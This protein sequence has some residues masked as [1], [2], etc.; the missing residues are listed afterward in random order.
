[1]PGEE[2]ASRIQ[3]RFSPTSKAASRGPNPAAAPIGQRQISVSAVRVGNAVVA[4]GK[5]E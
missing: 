5:K 1:M 2:A 3:S 4:Q